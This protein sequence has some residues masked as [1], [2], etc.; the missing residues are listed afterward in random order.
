MT[1]FG[2]KSR[3]GLIHDVFGIT[4]AD[5]KLEPSDKHG[6]SISYEYMV[7]TNQTTIFLSL[8]EAQRSEKKRLRNS[9]LRMIM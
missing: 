6:Q 4:P 1:A 9:L 8:I 7:K 5:Q 3:Y 2:P